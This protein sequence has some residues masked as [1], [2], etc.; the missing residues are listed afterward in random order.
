MSR[1]DGLLASQSLLNP[2]KTANTPAQTGKAFANMLGQA[3]DQVN[4]AKLQSDQEA[5]NMINGKA[6]NLHNVMISAQKAEITLTAAVEIR[7]KVI[8]AYQN[9]MRMQI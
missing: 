5:Q 9:I 2:Q 8:D 7:N 3:L 4:Q 1:I 6:T